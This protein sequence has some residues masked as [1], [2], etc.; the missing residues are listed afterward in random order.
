MVSSS[1][2][3][4]LCLS[5]TL[6]SAGRMSVEEQPGSAELRHYGYRGGR[7][8]A[9]ADAKYHELY[10]NGGRMDGWSSSDDDKWH[11]AG[12]PYPEGYDKNGKIDGYEGDSDEAEAA[13]ELTFLGMSVALAMRK[14]EFTVE[15]QIEFRTFFAEV[16]GSKAEHVRLTEV[17]EV[18]RRA[19]SLRVSFAIGVPSD[20]VTT[21]MTKLSQENVQTALSSKAPAGI[22]QMDVV[23]QPE[24]LASK[25]A[26]MLPESAPPPAPSSKPQIKKRGDNG[27]KKISCELIGAIVGG[28][29]LFVMGS[30]LCYTYAKARR[31]SSAR[32]PDS[33]PLDAAPGGYLAPAL[34]HSHPL[35]VLADD[36][37]KI[38]AIEAP[39]DAEK[40]AAAAPEEEQEMQ[41]PAVVVIANQPDTDTP[42]DSPKGQRE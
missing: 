30:V 40:P 28:V 22:S 6:V 9:E 31:A 25:P 29:V 17:T 34:V 12:N 4:A 16:A 42:P 18:R 15:K 38:S 35:G 14:D 32:A 8:N 3:V 1:L 41:Q 7:F 39:L 20:D 27:G 13:P 26:E 11:R 37:R 10:P 5:V 36:K 23:K 21:A 24:A 2:V 33:G 19:G